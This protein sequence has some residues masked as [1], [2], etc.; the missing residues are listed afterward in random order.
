[1][2]REMYSITSDILLPPL[3]G[4]CIGNTTIRFCRS[5]AVLGSPHG[6]IVRFAIIRG[7]PSRTVSVARVSVDQFQ[8]ITLN[9]P[10]RMPTR[11]INDITGIRFMAL[12]P[13]CFAYGL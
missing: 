4:H 10:F 1:M 13:E 9:V 6:R 3:I 8:S 2:L 7:E 5:L 12:G 11:A